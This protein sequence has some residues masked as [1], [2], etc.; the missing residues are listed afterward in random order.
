[1]LKALVGGAI[2]LG[3]VATGSRLALSPDGLGSRRRGSPGLQLSAEVGSDVRSLEVRLGDDLLPQV[4]PGR[5]GTTR[6]MTSTHSMVALT[7]RTRSPEPHIQINSRTAGS[8]RG[9]RRLAALHDLPDVASGED[10]GIAGTELVWIGDADGIQVKV[11]G[12]RPPDLTLV[13]LHPARRAEDARPDLESPALSESQVLQRGAIQPTA[14]PTLLKRSDWGADESWR[15]GKPRYNSTIQQVHVHHTVNSNDYALDDV[16]ALIRGMYH[17]HVFS[18]GWSDIAY[19]FLVDRFGR[20]WIGRAGGAARPVRGA[21]T[22]GF[23]ATSSGISAIG[24]FELVEPTASTLEAIAQV[25]AWK[26]SMYGRTATGQTHVVSEGSDRFMSGKRVTLPVLDGHRDTNDT[27]CPGQHLYDALPAIRA[28][29]QAIIE[30]SQ[31]P[32]IAITQP[33]VVTGSPIVGQSLT[34]TPGVSDPADAVP[35][36]S[37]MRNDVVIAGAVG[38]TY[39]AVADDL[40]TQLSVRV[41]R[42]KLGYAATAEKIGVSGLTKA[43]TGITVRAV[44]RPGKAMIHVTLSARGVAAVATGVVTVTVNHRTKTVDLASGAATAR[45]IDM[46]PGR[47]PVEVTYPGDAVLLPTQASSEVHVD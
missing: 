47:Y 22:L 44:G 40:G 39:V 38:V 37:W 14:R 43:A 31:Q 36:Y 42:T 24:N 7:W 13:L 26:L 21:H 16:P 30:A 19:N 41:E 5:W 23:N 46:A 28:R 35:S 8:W 11:T 33:S 17:Y 45:F 32:P 2:A 4:G 29:A 1:L 3:A 12:E 25:A 20:T 6:L 27:A 18:L 10:T 15:N 34:V 9:W